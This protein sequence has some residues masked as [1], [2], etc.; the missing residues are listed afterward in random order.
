MVK[1]SKKLTKTPFAIDVLDWHDDNN[2]GIHVQHK[3]NLH[4]K[5][6]RGKNGR[7]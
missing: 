3:I 4:L 2:G 7:N 1:Y 6:R 5:M